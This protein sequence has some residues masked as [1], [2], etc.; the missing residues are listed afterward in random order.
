MAFLQLIASRTLSPGRIIHLLTISVH[1]NTSDKSTSM[2][3]CSPSSEKN[4]KYAESRNF[5]S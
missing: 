2:R 5:C 4:V 3:R 1:L